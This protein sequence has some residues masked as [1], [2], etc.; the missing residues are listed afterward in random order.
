MKKLLITLILAIASFAATCQNF[1]TLWMGGVRDSTLYYWDDNW[2]DHYIGKLTFV[3]EYGPAFSKPIHA[4]PCLV[5]RDSLVIIGGA[6]A[7]EISDDLIGV[8]DTVLANMGPEYLIF[9]DNANKQMNEIGR[10]RYD[11]C[12]HSRQ[13]LE[14]LHRSGGSSFDFYPL[15]RKAMLENPIVVRD[16]FYIGVTQNNHAQMY[17]PSGSPT[18]IYYD[19]P[20][21]SIYKTGSMLWPYQDTDYYHH[22]PYYMLRSQIPIPPSSTSG[23]L[24]RIQEVGGLWIVVFPIFDTTD[25]YLPPIIGDDTLVVG[26]SCDSVTG[27]RIMEQEPASVTLTWNTDNHSR[28]EL[29]YAPEGSGPDQGERMELNAPFACISD[30]DTGVAYRAF[31]R[32]VCDDDSRSSWSHGIPFVIH[33]DHVGI[34]PSDLD[35]LTWLYP[36]P[37]SSGFRVFSSY[38]IREVLL[39]SNDGRLVF[40]MPVHASE[41]SADL[42]NLPQGVYLAVIRTA[43][44]DTTRKFI[45]Q[46]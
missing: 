32:T 2:I 10:T 29:S 20:G 6:V 13:R 23:T 14:L 7:A 27:F 37:A 3:A 45:I 30:C 42:S 8:A 41:A 17:G 11:T 9:Y 1:D 24:W 19:H 26:S 39:Y 28:W 33:G 4:R 5:N 34:H 46:R 38:H 36:N 43:Y 22:P 44:G 35:D 40:R 12:K 18:D 31:V 21:Y 16:S 15:L 25:H